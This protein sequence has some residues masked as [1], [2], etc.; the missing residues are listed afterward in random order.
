MVTLSA[1]LSTEARSA[2][3][4]TPNADANIPRR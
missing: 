3:V 4:E 2:K 1:D